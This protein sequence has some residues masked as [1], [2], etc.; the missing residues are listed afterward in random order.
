VSDVED[1]DEADWVKTTIRSENIRALAFIPLVA[2]GVAIGKFMTYYAAPRS[3]NS[4][5]IDLAVMIARQ[6]GFSIERFQ[7]E[8]ARQLAEQELRESKDRFQLMCEHAPVM[9]WMSDARGKCLHLNRLLRDFWGVTEDGI[10]GFDWSATVH[11]DDSAAIADAM[12]SAMAARHNVTLKG[13]YRCADGNYRVL[14]TDARP[15]VFGGEFLG[16][17]GVNIDITE[18]EEAEAA[19]KHA[20]TRREL[21]VAELNHR[22]KNT[23]SVVQAIANQTFR[24]TAQDARTAFDGRLQA[25]AR[26][27]DLLTKSDWASVSLRELAATAVQDAEESRVCLTGP[28]VLLLPTTAVAIGMILH[29]LFTNALKYGALSNPRGKVILEWACKENLNLLWREMGGPPVTAPKRNGFGSIL[30]ERMVKTE[31]QGDVRSE[32][33]ADGVFCSILA[34][35]PTL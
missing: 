11:P 5:E 28:D 24:G 30:V 4:R 35:T 15:H 10:A 6:V 34:R 26:S 18:R 29:E 13:R 22:V 12:T 8:R 17:I 7:A 9:I 16:M 23:L 2:Q 27:H 25:L 19:R 20:E 33:R 31:L 21:L 3:F 14:H 32:F 1:T